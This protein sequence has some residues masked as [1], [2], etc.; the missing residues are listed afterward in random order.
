MRAAPWTD[1]PG[2]NQRV[3]AAII[4]PAAMQTMLA[5]TMTGPA[6][7]TCLAR[8]RRLIFSPP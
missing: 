2:K 3:C 7:R 8:R 5:A 6:L 4:T 1:M